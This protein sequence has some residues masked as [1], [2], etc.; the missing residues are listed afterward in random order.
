MLCAD[1]T[2]VERIYYEHRLG[3]KPP[4]EQA[5]P[6]ALIE[7]LVRED[8]RKE[9]AL[10]KAYG[11]E[12]SAALLDAE[13]R[14]IQT[15]TRAPEM[16]A[17]IQTALGNDPAKFASHFAKP[18][19]VESLL[20]AHFDNDDAIH[21][22][23]RH[24][25]EAVRKQ[26]LDLNAG[27]FDSRLAALKGCRHGAVQ[28]HVAW[29]LTPRPADDT[30]DSQDAPPGPTQ[31]KASSSI[32]SIEATAQVAQTLASPEKDH[33][34]VER[35]QYFEDLPIQLQSLLRVQ[36]QQPGDVSAVVETPMAF[37]IYLVKDRTSSQ[38]RVAVFTLRKRS[39]EEWLEQQPVP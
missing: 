25:A 37:Q 30:A 2:A 28:E 22:P 32:Y 14:R 15:S 19:L 34:K 1:R 11:V 29:E 5:S 38:L 35:K 33:G 21:A 39:Y 24:I 27:G 7:K 8:L 36:L 6:P 13:V 23:Q 4:F 16:L 12:I 3:Q 9:S 26:L 31:N 10:R 17:A 18:F 20:R